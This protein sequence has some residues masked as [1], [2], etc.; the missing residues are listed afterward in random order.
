MRAIL[1]V[2]AAMIWTIIASPALAMVEW[3]PNT[4]GPARNRP[5]PDVALMDA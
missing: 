4:H 5:V 1:Q 2:D 3:N